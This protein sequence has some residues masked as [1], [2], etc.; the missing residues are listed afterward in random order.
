MYLLHKKQK[1]KPAEYTN[2]SQEIYVLNADY[3]WSLL[4][5]K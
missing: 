1:S 3:C 5:D 4:T 2:K